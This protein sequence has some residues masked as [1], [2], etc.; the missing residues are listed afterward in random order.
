MRKKT[1]LAQNMQEE[2]K[3]KKKRRSYQKDIRWE[4]LDNTGT[5]SRGPT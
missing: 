1:A 4:R 5:K 2:N 3:K